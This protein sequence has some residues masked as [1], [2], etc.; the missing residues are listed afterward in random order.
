MRGRIVV[1]FVL[2]ILVGSIAGAQFRRGRYRSRPAAYATRGDFDGSFQFCRIVFRRAPLGDGD[3]WNVDYPRADENLSIRLSELTKT[4]VGFTEEGTPKHLLINPRS[5][6]LFRCPFIMMTEV[7]ALDLDDAEVKGLREYL[8]KG[9]FLWADDFWGTR[10][11][12]VFESQM[13][14]VLPSGAY[15]IIDLPIEHPIFHELMSVDH[16]PQIPSINFWGGPGGRT[17]ERGADSAT[18]HARAILDDHR[19]VMVF[20]TH[21]TDFGDSFEREGDSR[22]YF[23]QFSVRGYAV[24]V[25]VLLYAMSH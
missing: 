6:E 21:N 11:W 12:E 22:Q 19:R 2:A 1:A 3:G 17:S 8:Q 15:P 25:N 7:G 24:G 9:G 13:R 23:L 5:P 10:A 14:K 4:S 18:P 16:I 20:I